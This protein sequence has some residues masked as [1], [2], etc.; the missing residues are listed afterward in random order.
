MTHILHRNT[1]GGT[2][3]RGSSMSQ[4]PD[5]TVC[6]QSHLTQLAMCSTV[7]INLW[8]HTGGPRGN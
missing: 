3:R 4:N 5:H 1:R 2:E 7:F 6:K 8:G